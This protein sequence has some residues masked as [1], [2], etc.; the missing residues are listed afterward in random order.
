MS[1]LVSC[2][3]FPLIFSVTFMLPRCLTVQEDAEPGAE[4]PVRNEPLRQP[5]V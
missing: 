4:P 5:S 1:I 3:F 2:F